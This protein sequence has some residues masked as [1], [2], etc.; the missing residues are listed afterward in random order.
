VRFRKHR[1]TARALKITEEVEVQIHEPPQ[2]LGLLGPNF[3]GQLSTHRGRHK[4]EDVLPTSPDG[5]L[6]AIRFFGCVG[7][8]MVASTLFVDQTFEATE[9]QQI[10][11]T[12]T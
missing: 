8:R 1:Y 12:L 3:S 5:R 2:S 7:K 6:D 9:T 10:L 4:S 11:K